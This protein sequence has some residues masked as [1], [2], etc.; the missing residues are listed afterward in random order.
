MK[1]IRSFENFDLKLWKCHLDLR[2]LMNCN[3]NGVIRKFLFSKLVNKHLK[4]SHV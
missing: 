4:N 3:K 2:F 1:K